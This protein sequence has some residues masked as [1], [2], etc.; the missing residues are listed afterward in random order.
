VRAWSAGCSSGEEAY[1]LAMLM[2]EFLDQQGKGGHL[3][4]V[5]V[6]ATDIDAR[7]LARANDA[8]YP[9]EA[10]GDVPASLASRYFEDNGSE[11][12]VIERVRRR[13]VVRASDLCSDPAP[14][15]SYQLILCRNVV[16]YFGRAMQERVFLDFAEAL[17]P[18]GFLVL[19]K[20]ES[21]S[22]RARDL[23]TLLDARERIYRRAA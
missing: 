8:Q 16:I 3:N 1:T 5:T 11:Y 9:R 19:G 22:G 20:V 4:R 17:A 10:L 23:L 21:L 7:C 15:R 12:R 6:D 18:G 14:R 13:V 2:A